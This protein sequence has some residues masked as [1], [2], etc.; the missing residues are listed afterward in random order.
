MFHT[1]RALLILCI[2]F[3]LAGVPT[4]AFGTAGNPLVKLAEKQNRDAAAAY[5]D[6]QMTADGLQTTP[7]PS[8]L[9]GDEPTDSK[10]AFI[11]TGGVIAVVI[12]VLLVI[13]LVIFRL[14]KK[15]PPGKSGQD[16]P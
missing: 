12:A 5:N 10:D 9:I 6:V 3:M 16:I 7:L 4:T 15:R 8:P 14:W 13:G 11:G 1:K 2:I